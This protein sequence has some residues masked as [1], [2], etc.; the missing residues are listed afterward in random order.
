MAW[1][2]VK[3]RDSLTLPYLTLPYL[4]KLS[5]QITQEITQ[6]QLYLTLPTLPYLILPY[7][8]YS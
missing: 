3:H 4:V 1:Y 7:Q 2:L 6:G 8:D 5:I